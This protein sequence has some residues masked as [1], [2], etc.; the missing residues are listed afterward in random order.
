MHLLRKNEMN[1]PLVWSFDNGRTP[2][3]LGT[4]QVK[5]IKTI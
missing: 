2:K 4:Y 1:A 5:I 3:Y